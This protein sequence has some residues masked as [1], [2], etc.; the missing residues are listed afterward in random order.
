MISVLRRKRIYAGIRLAGYGLLIVYLSIS[1]DFRFSLGWSFGFVACSALV[2]LVAARLLKLHERFP[3]LR[4]YLVAPVDPIPPPPATHEEWQKQ[5]VEWRQKLPEFL[6]SQLQL[7]VLLMTPA[8]D[9]LICVPLLLFGL[10]PFS[11]VAAAVAFG[12]LHL[13]GRTYFDCLCKSAI[14][15]LVCAIV[16]PHGLL[17]VVVGHVLNNLAAVAAVKILL[18][19][20]PA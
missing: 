9:G 3:R 18:R 15:G 14:Y 10:T 19:S 7:P 4:H 6:S 11:V 8:E 5:D 16:L 17:T 13:M 12:A 20:V 2:V 1:N